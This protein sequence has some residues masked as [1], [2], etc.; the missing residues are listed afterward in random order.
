MPKRV[1][2]DS[3]LLGLEHALEAKAAAD[4][5]RDH[6]DPALVE[7]KALASPER[8]MGGLGRGVDDELVEPLCQWATTPCPSSGA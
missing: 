3:D 2:H 4:V 8:M 1:A 5:G 6:A 7:A